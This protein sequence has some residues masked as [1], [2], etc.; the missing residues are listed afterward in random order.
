VRKKGQRRF[1]NSQK[2]ALLK[3]R[4]ELNERKLGLAEEEKA[5]RIQAY[6]EEMVLL[7]YEANDDAVR[8]ELAGSFY[9]ATGKR[10]QTEVEQ[11]LA[12]VLHSRAAGSQ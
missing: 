2:R 8:E 11:R 1:R 3:Q 5:F 9:A 4:L 10:L 6:T 12:S 7:W